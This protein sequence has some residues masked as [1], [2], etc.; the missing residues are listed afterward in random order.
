MFSLRFH[1]AAS[2]VL[3]C[4]QAEPA[5][6]LALRTGTGGQGLFDIQEKDGRA[7]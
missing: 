2:L 4:L 3:L 1:V 7:H 5:V 6:A